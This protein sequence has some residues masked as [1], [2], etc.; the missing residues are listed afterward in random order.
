MYE[1]I[2]AQAYIYV[3]ERIG[4]CL[5]SLI[6]ITRGR[7]KGAVTGAGPTTGPSH[8]LRSPADNPPLPAETLCER[9]E[10]G[11]VVGVWVSAGVCVFLKSARGQGYMPVCVC[12]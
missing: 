4:Q 12:V 10:L 7:S 1:P 2:E 8:S 3:S 6:K 11:D 9:G 5:G